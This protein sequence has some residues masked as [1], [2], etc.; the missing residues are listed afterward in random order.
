MGQKI[1]P[2][3][4]RLGSFKLHNSTWFAT[5]HSYSRYIFEDLFI[6]N[7]FKEGYKDAGIL[8]IKISRKLNNHSYISI[9][10][11]KPGYFLPNKPGNLKNARKLLETKL[12]YYKQS[13]FF[14]YLKLKNYSASLTDRQPSKIT[15]QLIEVQQIDAQASFLADFLIEQLEKRIAFRRALKK[16]LN[17]AEKSKIQ[18]IKIQIAGRLNGAEIART[19]WIREGRIPLQTLRANIDYSCKTAKT[20]YGLLGVK[21]WVFLENNAYF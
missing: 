2:I 5:K 21:I 7:F 18:G 1:H 6:R 9:F 20:I 14:N 16:T 4:F 12:T 11:T 17:R 15:I 10:L 13:S 19:E 3:G 8:H